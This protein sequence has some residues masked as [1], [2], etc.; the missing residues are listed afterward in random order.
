MNINSKSTKYWRLE[1]NKKKIAKKVSIERKK[2]MEFKKK[3]KGKEKGADL[4]S[5]PWN[6][7]DP[8]LYLPWI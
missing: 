6:P 1:V 3:R 5:Q 8:T 2:K 7:L 4:T